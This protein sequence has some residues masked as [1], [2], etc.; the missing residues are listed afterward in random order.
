MMY[1]ELYRYFIQHKKLAVP[2]VGTFLLERKPAENDFVNKQIIPPF[3]SVIL[4]AA[5]DSP[6]IY[7]FK[8][9]AEAQHISDRDA[10]IRFNDFVFG[11]KKQI[12][13]G[14]IINWHGVGTLSKGL[15]GEM[16][17]APPVES[18]LEKP[19]AAEKVIREKAEHMVRVGEDQRTSAEMTAWL[20]QPE[21]VK[22]WWRVTSLAV[23]LMALLFIGWYF[24][25]HGVDVSSTAN[26]MKLVPMEAGDPYQ[27]LP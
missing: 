21:S 26:N 10:I 4:Q 20:K 23:G 17:F 15:A 5:V 24:S 9:L 25:E 7:F 2:G 8:W 18:A 1:E 16:K 14:D 13:E 11:L 27:I 22:S 6:S 12:T 3:Y 19:V